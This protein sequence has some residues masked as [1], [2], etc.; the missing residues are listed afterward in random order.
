VASGKRSGLNGERVGLLYAAPPGAG[1]GAIGLSDE[2]TILVSA[3][4]YGGP[5]FD[6]HFV[7]LMGRP[8]RRPN[9]AE[10]TEAGVLL[11]WHRR[12]VF[13]PPSRDGV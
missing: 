13:R 6:E 5:R 3:H 2:L 1:P 7:S 8:L 10:S 4:V 11:E 12:E 9:L